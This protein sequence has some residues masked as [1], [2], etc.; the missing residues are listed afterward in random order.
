MV[1]CIWEK[2]NILKNNAARKKVLKF[3]LVIMLCGKATEIQI[4]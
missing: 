1:R 4:S 3:S 2:I